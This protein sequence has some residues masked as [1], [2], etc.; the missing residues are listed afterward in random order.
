MKPNDCKCPG[1]THV[2]VRCFVTPT[3][4]PTVR[5]LLDELGFREVRESLIELRRIK[6]DPR[7]DYLNSEAIEKAKQ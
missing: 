2:N 3:P 5:E 1:D 7:S 4:S 6:A